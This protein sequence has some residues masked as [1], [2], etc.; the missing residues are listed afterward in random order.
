MVE[1]PTRLK[2]PKSERN[3]IS[4]LITAVYKVYRQDKTSRDPLR[5]SGCWDSRHKAPVQEFEE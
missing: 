3:R 5:L 1:Q 2:D 4:K